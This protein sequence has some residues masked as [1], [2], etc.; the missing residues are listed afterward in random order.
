MK[1]TLS[2]R[3]S[4]K[5]KLL[6]ALIGTNLVALL[7]LTL[8]SYSATNTLLNSNF[9]TTSTQTLQQ[10]DSSITQFLQSVEMQSKTLAGLDLLQNL[11]DANADA[12][13][14]FAMF[15]N[16]T[17]ESITNTSKTI[18]GTY[19]VDHELNQMYIYPESDTSG[20]TWSSKSWYQAAVANPGESN[21]SYPY[22]DEITGKTIF[23]L[24]R[25]VLVDN[26]VIGVI[27]IDVDL[28]LVSAT[29]STINIGE[30][31]YVFITDDR[32]ILVAHPDTSM[33]NTDAIAELK[34][35]DFLA[36]NDSGFT[37]Y[38]FNGTSKF[39]NFVT[40]SKTGWMIVASIPTSELSDDTNSILFTSLIIML[41]IL[42]VVTILA[43]IISNSM[44]KNISLLQKVMEK[45]AS[46]DLTVTAT[47]GSKDE[48]KSLGNS[49]NTMISNI[50]E[51]IYNVKESS[52]TVSETSRSITK[53]S[54]ETS[55][56]MTEIAV[57]ISEVA[58]GNNEQSKDIEQNSINI[59]Q[60][61]QKLG[62][63]ASSTNEVGELSKSTKANSNEGMNQIKRL[64][65]STDESAKI[66]SNVSEIMMELNRA[67]KEINS[68][69]DTINSLAEQ[70]NLLALN[71][72][73]EAARAGE[74]G[75]GFAV[76][77]EEIRKLAEQSSKA[78]SD[79]GSLINAMNSRSE[80]ATKAI[81]SAGSNT[82]MQ[83]NAVIETNNIFQKI[84]TSIEELSSK[85]GMIATSISDI[86][87]QKN[88]IVGSTANLSAIS[89]EISASTEEVSASTEEVSA[90]SELF[91]QHAKDLSVLADK[92]IQQINY[93]KI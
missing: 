41:A 16:N 35:W 19:F 2:F 79:I 44:I 69:T 42:L 70:T 65:D 28:S 38:N 60:L 17:L 10:A 6:F 14:T 88:L 39:A 3:S 93:F 58:A 4:I 72:A 27:G 47:I 64:V 92:L 11:V 80:E 81:I 85:V 13:E 77:A 89:E 91:T 26:K 67:S 25:A 57:T 40:N 90:S 18:V 24:S 12:K 86:D 52:I 45:A 83:N 74:S 54:A 50:K 59:N 51:L 34:L 63:I 43:V 29:L 82:E 23:T 48:I 20:V 33:I 5:N 71:A 36:A 66:A 8:L 9:K 75:R 53:M 31:G 21:W 1:N 78:T 32:G 73:I 46:G 56:A 30:E 7:I 37:E 55:S 61:A 15:L 68:I 87:R 49:F 62:E 84:S 22:I 76:V